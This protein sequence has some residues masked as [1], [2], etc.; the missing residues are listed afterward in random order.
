MVCTGLSQPHGHELSRTK[1]R[2]QY[3]TDS[4]R[5]HGWLV[6]KRINCISFWKEKKR[7]IQLLIC[8][9]V[10]MDAMVFEFNEY[11]EAWVGMG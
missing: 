11:N 8:I 5:H 4:H 3:D 2:I 1:C 7:F 10:W 9:T 6:F